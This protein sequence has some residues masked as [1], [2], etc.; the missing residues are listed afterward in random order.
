MTPA[1]ALEK[2]KEY[3]EFGRIS[4]EDHALDQMEARNVD[5]EDVFCAL[6]TASI[7]FAQEDERWK[8]EGTDTWGDELA[9]IVTFNGTVCVLTVF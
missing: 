1:E 6:E 9:V 4:F 2:I 5:M 3:A 7:C 8:V